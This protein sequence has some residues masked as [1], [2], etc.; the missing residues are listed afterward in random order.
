MEITETYVDDMIRAVRRSK[1]DAIVP[2]IC[3]LICEARADLISAGVSE[4]KA[5][6]END[7]LIKGAIRCFVRWKFGLA[8]EETEPNRRDYIELKD[9]IRRNAAYM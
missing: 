7:P 3:D 8:S 4:E 6:N 2:E 1:S 9:N 5:N